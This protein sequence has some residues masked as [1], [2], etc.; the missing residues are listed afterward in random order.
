[1]LF[2]IYH[3]AYAGDSLGLHDPRL[4][5]AG[6]E[7]SARV[8]AASERANC[9]GRGTPRMDGEREREIHIYIYIYINTYIQIHIYI[10]M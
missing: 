1:M 6:E 5:C 4:F 2:I 9:Q 8:E 10:Y 3:I 7:P